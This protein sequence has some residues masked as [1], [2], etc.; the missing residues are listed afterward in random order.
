MGKT[1][2]IAEKPSVGQDLARVLPGPFK[3]KAGTGESARR[4]GSK[5]PSTSSPGRSGTSC[6]LADPDEYD[7]KFAKWRMADLPIVPTK[8]K[9]VVRDERS[10]KQ[11][12]VVRATCA[13]RRG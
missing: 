4:A 13:V 3:K 9:L 2:V 6:S 1:L 7:E 5:A 11:M 10:Q 8:F 12:K